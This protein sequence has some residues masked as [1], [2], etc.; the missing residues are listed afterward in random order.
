M[1]RWTLAFLVLTTAACASQR[2]QASAARILS[3]HTHTVQS[4]L[5]AF[6]GHRALANQARQRSINILEESRLHR[7]NLNDE[8]FRV[9]QISDGARL[10]LFKGVVAATEAAAS[11]T[12]D[13]EAQRRANDALLASMKSQVATR[14]EQLQK[15][16]RLLA[17]LGERDKLKAQLEFYRAFWSDVKASVDAASETSAQAADAAAKAPGGV[18]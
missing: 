9:W 12:A 15:T 2:E 13:A 3:L 11:R 1:K 10:A 17:A 6:A 18:Q 5:E 4:E 14:R 8:Q 7:E 16:A